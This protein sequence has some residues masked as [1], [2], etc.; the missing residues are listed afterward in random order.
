MTVRASAILVALGLVCEYAAAAGSA[1]DFEG[2]VLPLLAQHCF[3][4]HGGEPKVRSGLRLTSLEGWQRGGEMGA[5]VDLERFAEPSRHRVLAAL[6]Y[7]DEQLQMPPRGKLAEADVAIL[8]RWIAA[9]MPWSEVDDYGVPPEEESHGATPDPL[10][11]WSYRELPRLDAIEVP[12]VANAAWV[13]DPLDAFVL[14]RLE[15]AGLAPSPPQEDAAFL[16]RLTFDLTGLPPAPG[17]VEAFVADLAPHKVERAVDRLLASPHYGERMA[18]HWL[19]LVRFAETNGFERDSDKPYVW[20]YR[21]YVIDAFNADKPYDRFVLE[22][23]A[24]DEIGEPTPE[25]LTATGYYRLMQWDDEPPSGPLQARYDVLDDVVRTTGET[26]LAMSIGCARCHDH[27]ADPISQ[28]DYHRVLAVFDG[29]TDYEAKGSLVDVSPPELRAECDRLEAEQ[30]ADSARVAAELAPYQRDLASALGSDVALSGSRS[31]TLWRYTTEDPGQGFE[32]PEFDDSSWT[33][34]RGGFGSKGTPGAR[35]GVEWTGDAIWMRRTFD[36]D[37]DASRFALIAHHDDDLEVYVNGVLAAQANGYV[38]EYGE[39]PLTG[40]GRAALRKGVNRIAVHCVQ[41]SG[42]QYVDVVPVADRDAALATLARVKS[43]EMQIASIEAR[44]VPRRFAPAARE[45]PELRTTYVMARGNAEARGKVVTPGIPAV[46]DSRPMAIAPPP[47][48]ATSSHRRLAFAQWLVDPRNPLT[49]RVIANRLFQ[50]HFGRGIVRSSN[51]FGEL[52]TRP[53]HPE[54]LDHLAASLIAEGWSLK[55][56]HRRIV[57]S[58]TYR[59]SNRGSPVGDA[60]LETDP[61]NELLW[62]F[63]ARRLSAEEIRDAMLAV[64][65][66]LDARVGGPSFFAPMPAEVLATSS[67]PEEAWGTSPESELGRRSLYVKTKRSLLHPF[68]TVFDFADVDS[69]CPVRFQTTQPT[70]ALAMLNSPEVHA[71]ARFA[72]ERLARECADDRAAVELLHRLA[73]ARA[74]TSAE[75]EAALAFLAMQRERHSRDRVTALSR[76]ALFVFNLNEFVY[77]D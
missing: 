10:R 68:L 57:T 34:G 11:G 59:M 37:G 58:A 28:V 31:A 77:L 13:K 15:A 74:P 21:D 30:R 51:D 41:R 71:Q 3:A 67:R 1:P 16:R 4:C 5:I 6:G 8:E 38:V 9:G 60:A 44:V 72:G 33:E 50:W 7:A 65:G 19:D 26:F 43:L 24:G 66:R 73:L 35:I 63:E 61:T 27:K 14:A 76:L 22:Q 39:L 40:A 47:V 18:R 12:D 75:R 2:E 54:L 32:R 70:Q 69:G 17:D 64:N 46:L 56:L 48:G 36:W 49:A 45:E 55:A 20:R 42:G 23:L 29:L 25:S 53:T 52:G 62:R